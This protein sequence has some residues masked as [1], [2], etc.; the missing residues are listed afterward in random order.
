MPR[1]KNWKKG[2]VKE[3]NVNARREGV[4]E[5]SASTER[6]VSERGKCDFLSSR[7]ERVKERKCERKE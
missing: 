1:S 7:S 2:A 5:G 4:K 3:R 6:G